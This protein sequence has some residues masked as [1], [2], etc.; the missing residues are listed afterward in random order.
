MKLKVPI[1]DKL[2]FLGVISAA[3]G[4]KGEVIIKTFNSNPEQLPEMNIMDFKGNQIN[5]DLVRIHP[6]GGIIAKVDG[7]DSRTKAEHLAKTK[8]Y[9]YRSDLPDTLE[10]E[11]YITDLVGM[12]VK[13]TKGDNIGKV[14]AVHN[15]GAGD[16]IEVEFDDSNKKEMYPFTQELFPEILDDY[17]V[18][19][20]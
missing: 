20:I 7:C 15:F 14:S 2:I 12:V 4:I 1:Q 16:I 11:F 19:D 5:L 10:D 6:K 18:A 17:I 13:N 3:Y 9:C 8:L